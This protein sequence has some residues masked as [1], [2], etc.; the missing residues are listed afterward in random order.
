LAAPGKKKAKDGSK[1][2]SNPSPIG[3]TLLEGSYTLAYGLYLLLK[4]G[5]GLDKRV[6]LALKTA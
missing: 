6:N 1:K 5:V 3:L 2:S 4:E